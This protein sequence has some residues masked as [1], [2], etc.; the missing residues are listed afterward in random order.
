MIASRGVLLLVGFWLPVGRF[1]C[2]LVF[3]CLLVSFAVGWFLFA[4]WSVLLLVGFTVGSFLFACWSVLLLVGFWLSAGQ[5]CCWGVLLLGC[6]VAGS[7]RGVGL[8]EVAIGFCGF[9]CETLEHA[10]VHFEA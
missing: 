6:F 5:F 1:C 7:D 3:V 10:I 9:A 4:C 2:W 8:L